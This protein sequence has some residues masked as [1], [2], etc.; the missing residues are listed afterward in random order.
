MLATMLSLPRHTIWD[1][2][3]ICLMFD[4]QSP[5]LIA[6]KCVVTFHRGL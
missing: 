3:N 6:E 1:G 4:S 5:L 2:M